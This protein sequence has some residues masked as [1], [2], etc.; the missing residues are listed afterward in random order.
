MDILEKRKFYQKV[1][2]ECWDFVKQLQALR[3]LGKT[4]AEILEILV[5][6]K[7]P[8]RKHLFITGNFTVLMDAKIR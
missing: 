4:D 8:L 3:K 7:L 6:L 1:P 2:D 5:S